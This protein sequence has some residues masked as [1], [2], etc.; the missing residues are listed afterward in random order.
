MKNIT[1]SIDE[2]IYDRARIVAAH[3]KTSLS[4]MVRDYLKEIAQEQ[5][6]SDQE[7]RDAIQ[8][9]LW[10]LAEDRAPNNARSTEPLSR[11]E[12]YE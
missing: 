12:I 11:G 4:A 3:R 2:V 10:V 9:K 6:D 5:L 1:L 7:R 8:Q